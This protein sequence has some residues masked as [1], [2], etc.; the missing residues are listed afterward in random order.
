M[1]NDFTR[2]TVF[3]AKWLFEVICFDVYE[4]SLAITYS[5]IIILVSYRPMNLGKI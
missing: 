2:K 3:N 4:K 1:L 5:D